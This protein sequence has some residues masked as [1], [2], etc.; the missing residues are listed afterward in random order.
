MDHAG[1]HH[2]VP[3]GGEIATGKPVSPSQQAINT[4]TTLRVAE[5]SQHLAQNLAPSELQLLAATYGCVLAALVI[6]A[7]RG[8]PLAPR[9]AATGL[10]LLSPYFWES[11]LW[12]ATDVAAMTFAF[13]ALIVLIRPQLDHRQALLVVA[14]HQIHGV[15]PDPLVRTTIFVGSSEDGFLEEVRYAGRQ[16]KVSTLRRPVDVMCVDPSTSSLGC[17]VR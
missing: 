11:T 8:M 10:V 13:R 2:R 3:P 15:L 14:G 4:S 5:F 12:M 9:L 7:G 16:S 6:V 1:L 17:L